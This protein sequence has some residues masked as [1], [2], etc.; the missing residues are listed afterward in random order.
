MTQTVRDQ[1]SEAGHDVMQASGK[2]AQTA[3]GQGKQVAEE[4]GRQARSVFDQ[5]YARMR[6]EVD[7]Q[8][9]R[10]VER[11]RT[12]GDELQSMCGQGEK[13][14][15]AGTLTRQAAGVAHQVADW[16]QQREPGELVHE[17]REY[18]RRNPGT[19]LAG[20]T[21]A[22]ML[23]GRL[24]KNLSSPSGMAG[25]GDGHRGGAQPAGERPMT[26]TG[27]GLA[28]AQGVEPMGP[29]GPDMPG[30]EPVG[31]PGWAPRAHAETR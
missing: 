6:N 31:E 8:Q 23:A 12:L 29:L 25:G 18:A 5:A 13:Q 17:L 10:A 28:P 7:A 4:T 20:A 9:R 19:F 15:M 27:M 22:G 11:L 2:M 1:T 3:V 16:L 21:V 30:G 24:T 26:R 14:D